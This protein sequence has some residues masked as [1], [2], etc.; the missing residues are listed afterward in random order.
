VFLEDDDRLVADRTRRTAA[1]PHLGV[2]P[3]G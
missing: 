1:A 2:E 3:R